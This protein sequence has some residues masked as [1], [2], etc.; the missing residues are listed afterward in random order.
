MNNRK[1]SIECPECGEVVELCISCAEI[2]H[3]DDAKAIT[4][5]GTY[6]GFCHKRKFLEGQFETLESQEIEIE[7]DVAF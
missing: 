4:G 7:E 6:C 5:E 3:E 1:E 2:V